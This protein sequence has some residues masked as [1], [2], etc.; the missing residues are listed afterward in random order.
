MLLTSLAAFLLQHRKTPGTR[1]VFRW[2]SVGSP[3]GLDPSVGLGSLLNFPLEPCSSGVPAMMRGTLQT[4]SRWGSN[5][6]L[7]ATPVKRRVTPGCQ[8]SGRSGRPP[9]ARCGAWAPDN[10]A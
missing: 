8:A 7:M 9:Q 1:A 6:R 4:N 2:L 10:A 3:G 5:R